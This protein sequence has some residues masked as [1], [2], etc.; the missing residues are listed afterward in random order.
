MGGRLVGVLGRLRYGGL[1][2]LTVWDHVVADLL[3]FVFL[4]PL[5]L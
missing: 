1:R 2:S 4:P 5:S 3:L